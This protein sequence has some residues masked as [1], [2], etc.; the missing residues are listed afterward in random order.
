[1]PPTVR[2]PVRTRS[3]HVSDDLN[4]STSLNDARSHG[5]GAGD[6][7]VDQPQGHQV[8]ERL[9]LPPKVHSVPPSSTAAGGDTPSLVCLSPCDIVGNSN[10]SNTTTPYALVRAMAIDLVDCDTGASQEI[11]RSIHFS[12]DFSRH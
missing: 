4:R 1:M 10:P 6:Q 11:S 3:Q 12:N 5:G 7:V 2:Q 9:R 8:L